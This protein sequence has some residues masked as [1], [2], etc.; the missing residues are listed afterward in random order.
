[1]VFN[2]EVDGQHVYHVASS[3]LL[4]HNVCPW[5]IGYSRPVS[6]VT[7]TFAHG[8]WKGRTLQEAIDEAKRTGKLPEGL[9]L[10]ADLI[11]DQWVAANNRTLFVAQEA[12]LCQVHPTT[13]AGT[14]N[15]ILKH[16]SET[17]IPLW[18]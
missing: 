6:G 3:G 14:L 11:N 2:L 7:E 9:E 12:G 10:H 18:R 1:M 16:L 13:G 5:D 15:S 8:P 17:G 4:V